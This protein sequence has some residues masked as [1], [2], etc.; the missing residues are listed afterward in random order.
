[1]ELKPPGKVL[2]EPPTFKP[3]KTLA[4]S[5][6]EHRTEWLISRHGKE[7]MNLNE[8]ARR[9]R[10]KLSANPAPPCT[11]REGRIGSSCAPDCPYELALTNAWDA[12][13]DELYDE[14]HRSDQL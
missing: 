1:M 13:K 2:R 8:I 11:C 6:N 10:Q 3:L 12:A 5:W 7:L 4:P 14:L 9:T